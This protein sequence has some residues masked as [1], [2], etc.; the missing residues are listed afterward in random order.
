MRYLVGC[1]IICSLLVGCATNSEKAQEMLRQ[2][3]FAEVIT[4][5]AEDQSCE[6]WRTAACESLL[7]QREYSLVLGLTPETF[8]AQTI[9]NCLAILVEKE[10]RGAFFDVIGQANAIAGRIRGEGDRIGGLTKFDLLQMMVGQYYNR[11]IGESQLYDGKPGVS[12]LRELLTQQTGQMYIAP[13]LT[14]SSAL[15]HLENAAS[16]LGEIDKTIDPALSRQYGLDAVARSVATKLATIDKELS[17]YESGVSQAQ[18]EFDVSTATIKT[19]NILASI[20]LALLADST[21]ELTAIIE[22]GELLSATSTASNDPWSVTKTLAVPKDLES[23]VRTDCAFSPDLKYFAAVGGSSGN[24]GYSWGAIVVWDLATSNVVG[25]YDTDSWVQRV[26]F[27][28]NRLV[29]IGGEFEY[30]EKVLDPRGYGEVKFGRASEKGLDKLE[31]MHKYHE[32]LR[33][34]G[35]NFEIKASSEGDLPSVRATNVKTGNV[36]KIL[37]GHDDPIAFSMDG[38]L[39]ATYQPN[40]WTFAIWRLPHNEIASSANVP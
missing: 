38:G 4:T 13:K 5:F 27:V 31:G 25:Q 14:M 6:A 35:D 30:I 24:A 23:P 16:T 32:S 29:V 8:Q 22:Q 7:A 36:E 19:N 12:W 20:A 21:N 40:E 11:P 10:S 34:P 9:R 37:I 39:M 3:N 28:E 17:A 15:V 2:G 1:V 18:E 26:S 33:S